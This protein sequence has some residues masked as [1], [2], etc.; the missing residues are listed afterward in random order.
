[1]FRNIIRVGAVLL[2]VA[3]LVAGASQLYSS[4][5][6]GCPQPKGKCLCPQIVMPVICDGGCTYINSCYAA[7]AR[8]RNCV[9][10]PI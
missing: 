3:V 2:V 8:A 6:S 10:A 1:M 9:P 7:C 5:G 4:P